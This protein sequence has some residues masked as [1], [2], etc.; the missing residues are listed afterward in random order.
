[1]S[2]I[3]VGI[4]SFL[5]GTAVDYLLHR[6]AWQAVQQKLEQDAAMARHINQAM[7]EVAERPLDTLEGSKLYKA[8]EYHERDPLA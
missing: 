7:R 6:R 5:L 2:Y 8:Y 1:M 3:T 4:I